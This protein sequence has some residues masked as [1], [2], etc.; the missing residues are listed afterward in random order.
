MTT[1]RELQRE[2]DTLA[3][4]DPMWSAL[5]DPRKRGGKWNADEFFATGEREVATVLE[6][7][8]SIGVPLDYERTVLDFGC[9]VG[10]LSQALTQ[11]M[12]C[13]GVD[14]SPTMIERARMLNRHPKTCKY[15]VNDSD[16]LGIFDD[17]DFGFVYSSIVLQHMEP[18]FAEGYLRE[19][20]RVLAPGG[21]AVFQAVESRRRQPGARGKVAD[22][23]GR[24]RAVLALRWRLQALRW[25]ITSGKAAPGVLRCEM[26][27]LPESRV[28]EVVAPA[29]GEVIDVRLTNSAELGFNGDLEYR[30]PSAAAQGRWVSKQYCVI[31]RPVGPPPGRASR[32]RRTPSAS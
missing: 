7:L 22:S 29:G 14:I 32:R 16:G 21:V 26:H 9:G 20:I 8:E 24:M 31:K 18:H 30:E 15:L 3:H 6:H 11:R 4:W 5:M 25:R 28:R 12:G 17:G 1:L 2:W 23:V 27:T 19:F 10:R 13:V